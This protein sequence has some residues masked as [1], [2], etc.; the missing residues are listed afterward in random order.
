MF[1]FDVTV[2]VAACSTTLITLS[3]A[4]W[5]NPGVCQVMD[6]QMSL[7][8]C[9]VWAQCTLERLYS[10]VS[11]MM[12]FEALFCCCFVWTYWTLEGVF[13]SMSKMMF[14]QR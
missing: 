8:C 12:P 6:C 11:K 13:R 4:K 2:E 5:F 1:D 9:F 3:A 7:L 14:C 10:G